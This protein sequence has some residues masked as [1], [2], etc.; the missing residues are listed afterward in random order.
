MRNSIKLNLLVWLAASLALA[1]QTTKEITRPAN[2][3]EDARPNSSAV[4]D[5][6]AITGQFQRVTTAERRA[7]GWI[8]LLWTAT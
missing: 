5:V 8:V 6:Y 7:P 2:P 3:A 4:P 1:Q